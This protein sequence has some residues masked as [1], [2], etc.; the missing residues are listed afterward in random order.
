MSN[1]HLVVWLWCSSVAWVSCRISISN[2]WSRVVGRWGIRMQWSVRLDI[3]CFRVIWLLRQGYLFHLPLMIHG[4]SLIFSLWSKGLECSEMQRRRQLQVPSQL[5]FV[6]SFRVCIKIRRDRADRGG[7]AYMP[8]VRISVI[9][10]TST[11]DIGDSKP[12]TIHPKTLIHSRAC[13]LLKTTHNIP[14]L[15][16]YYKTSRMFSN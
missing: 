15:I 16:V 1:S 10:R 9:W 13:F 4:S 7:C 14:L 2:D 3:A 5:R 8:P 12:V 11:S 6:Y